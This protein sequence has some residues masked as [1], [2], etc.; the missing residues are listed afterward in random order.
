MKGKIL[1]TNPAATGAHV[2]CID[3]DQGLVISGE[4]IFLATVSVLRTHPVSVMHDPF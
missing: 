2:T 1:I 4:C 3:D